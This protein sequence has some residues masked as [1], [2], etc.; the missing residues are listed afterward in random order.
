M[1]WI[2]TDQLRIML[3]FYKTTLKDLRDSFEY[4]GRGYIGDSKV[5]YYKHKW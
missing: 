2:K 4:T 3:E 1:N 5:I